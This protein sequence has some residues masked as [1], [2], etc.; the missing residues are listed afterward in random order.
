MSLS[1][2]FTAKVRA[3]T[4]C[5]IWIGATN[6]KGYGILGIGGGVRALAHR[7]AYEAEYG[8]IPDGMVIDHVCRVRNCVNPLHL[9]PVSQAENN[10]RGRNAAALAVGDVCQN[11][12]LIGAGDLYIRTD[13]HTECHHCRRAGN[14][15]EAG[16]KR[17][18]PTRQRRAEIVGAD[19]AAIDVSRQDGAA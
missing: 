19:L 10:R 8:P 3:D 9:E 13:G 2:N 5:H 16:V 18:R 7:V 6:N 12:H 11:G 14:K 1:E 4:G 15:R 17:R